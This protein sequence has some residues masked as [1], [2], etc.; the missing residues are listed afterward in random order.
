MRIKISILL[1]IIVLVS[2]AAISYVFFVPRNSYR[3]DCDKAL[4][5]YDA[6]FV[7]LQACSHCKT[8]FARMQE[9]NLTERFY[10]ID[11]ESSTC[12]KVINDYSDYIVKHKNSNAPDTQAGIATPTKVCLRDNK[13][14]VGEMQTDQM[15]EFYENCTGVKI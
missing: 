14:Y 3:N 7:Y 13:T 1:P 5:G 6:F 9:L 11:A 12:K 8:D 10:M 2:I 15:K 4:S